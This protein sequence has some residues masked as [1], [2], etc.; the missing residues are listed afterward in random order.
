M[1][2]GENVFLFVPNLIGYAR[3]ALAAAAF[4]LMPREPGPAAACYGLSGLLDALDGHL[5]RLLGQGS[6]LGAMLDMLTDRLSTM[7][8]L[9]NLAL[10]YPAAAPLFQLSMA[11]DVAS[12]WLHMHCTTLQGGQSHK[13]VGG[14]VHPLLRLYYGSRPLLFLL[15]AGNEGFYCCLYLLRFGEGPPVVPGGPGLF[16]VGLWLGAPLA[17]L[18]G[19]LNLLQL[20]GAAR[21]LAALDAAERPKSR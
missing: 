8:L 6:R 5:A 19:G 13:A 10:L 11:L 9:V 1:A 20:G 4:Y 14:E 21:R 18:K 12:H 7:C 16:R 2:G 17:A 15:C 3:L